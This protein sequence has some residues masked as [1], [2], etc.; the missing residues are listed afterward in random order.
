MKPVQA[1]K[2]LI[3]AISTVSIWRTAREVHLLMLVLTLVAF[4]GL[5]G[6]G[7]AK[8]VKKEEDFF[9]SGSRD[10]DQRASQRMAKDQQL[11]GAGE[12]SA[13]KGAK[14]ARLANPG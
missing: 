2:K 12:G 14:K 3:S 1:M 4:V 5:V 10:A 13:E 7:T 9:T 6:C 11:T 8:V